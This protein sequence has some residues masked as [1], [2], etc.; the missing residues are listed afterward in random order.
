MSSTKWSTV[1]DVDE[2]S[3]TEGVPWVWHGSRA[4]PRVRDPLSEDGKRVSR[5]LILLSK[6]GKEGVTVREFDLLTNRFLVEDAFSIPDMAKARVSYKSRDVLLVGSDFGPGSMTRAGFPRTIREWYRGTDMK[7][8]KTVFEGEDSDIAVTSYIDDERPRGG[9]LYEVRTRILGTSA[10]KYW[11]RKVKPEQ[12]LPH[13]D[14][15]RQKAGEPPEFKQLLIPESSEIDFLGNLLVI[16]LGSDWSPEDGKN[17][18][19]GSMIYVNSHKF[20]KY[21][22]K[23]R[24]Y[25]VLFEPKEFLSC[26]DYIVTKEFLVLCVSDT[27]KSRLEFH[28]LEKDAN[29][30]RLVGLDKKP[31]VRTI[32]VRAVDP[33]LSNKFWLTTCT[34]TEP[35]TLSLADASKMDTDDKKMI[36]KTGSEG[37]VL[38]KLK[39][40]PTYFD[41]SNVEVCQKLATS[42]DGTKIPYFVISNKDSEFKEKRNPTLLYAHGSQGVSLGPRYAGPTGIAWIERG[43]VY[44]EAIVR[45]GGEFSESWQRAGIRENAASSVE[46]LIAVAE[47]LIAAKICI[48]KTLAL[49]GGSAGATTV[50]AAY[51]SKPDLFGVVHCASP[52]LDL[53]RLQAMEC[54]HSW[55][56]E[57]GDPATEDWNKF[58]KRLSPLHVIDESVNKYPPALFTTAE[59]GAVVHPGHARKM[60]KKLW[61]KGL[62]KKW[63]AFY[64]ETPTLAST[65]EQY[66]FATTLAYDFLFKKVTKTKK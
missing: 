7:D 54:P 25:H 6:D 38:K 49:R 31:Q 10:S 48:P 12:L 46:D 19:A 57:L 30:L 4:L 64:Y 2:L 9:G 29:K 65:E 26:Q 40:L 11:V 5:V 50:A 51:L 18:T 32:N 36:R 27:M 34:Y 47:D 58:M 56:L 16:I 44:V 42:K 21:G 33:Y 17:F 55:L 62:G 60:V 15:K 52:L 1:L 63:P 41:S 45:G 13:D 28:R 43:G 20:V 22:P 8:A 59:E 53:R 66:A 37:Y 35:M 24:I 23:D 61:D 3:K 39:S 14:P